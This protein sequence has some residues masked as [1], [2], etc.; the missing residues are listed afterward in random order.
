M[1]KTKSLDAVDQEILRVL[2]LYEQLSQSELWF[3]IGEARVLGPVTKE[4][5]SSRLESLKG[6]GFLERISLGE[7]NIRWALN[8]SST[9]SEFKG[10]QMLQE[11]VGSEGES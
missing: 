10:M 1:G 4:Q 7:G 3:E 11:A 6:R 2:S 9:R 8:G 5:V